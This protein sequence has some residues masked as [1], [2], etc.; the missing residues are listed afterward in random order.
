MDRIIVWN[1]ILG[2]S[3]WTGLLSET[4]FSGFQDGQDYCPI[5]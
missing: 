3:G 4:G 1:R 2:I 5:L